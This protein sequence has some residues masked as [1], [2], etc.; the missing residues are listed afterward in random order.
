MLHRVRRLAIGTA[1]VRHGGRLVA[2]VTGVTQ[3]TR[4]QLSPDGGA[5]SMG[6]PAR[7]T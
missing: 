1:E 4:L 5:I 3:L 6:F 2:T 7:L